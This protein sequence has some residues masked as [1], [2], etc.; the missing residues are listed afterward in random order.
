MVVGGILRVHTDEGLVGEAHTRRGVIVSDLV[1]R[2]IREDLIGRDPL[3][4][5]L[6][7]QRLWELDRIEELPVYALGL[8]DVALWDLAY[9]AVG[10]PVHQLL[11]T[12]REAIPAYASTV[13]FDSVEEYLDVATQCL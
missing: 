6:L 7:W 8:V 2:R 4:R 3:M 10:Q 5:E 9:K 12:Y 13:T 1:D 11:G